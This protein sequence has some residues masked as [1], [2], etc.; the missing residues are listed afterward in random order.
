MLPDGSV[1][2]GQMT[3]FNHY[4]LGSV[5]DWMHQN[6]LGLQVKEPGWRE[7]I[8]HPRP[9]GNIRWAE[10]EHVSP[11]DRHAVRWQICDLREGGQMEF[12]IEIRVPPNTTAHVQLPGNNDGPLVRGSGVHTVIS[13]FAEDEHW[14]PEP[15]VAPNVPVPE[16]DLKYFD[17]AMPCPFNL[18]Q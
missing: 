11:Y 9:G 8:V 1:N 5:A 17:Q 7:F 12:R 14:P 6:I 18:Q 16:E 10:G 4:A 15:I 2:P 3:S 13:D